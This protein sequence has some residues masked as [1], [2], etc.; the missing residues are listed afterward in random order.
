MFY[1]RKSQEVQRKTMSSTPPLPHPQ[2]T[3]TPC[4]VFS[5]G[6]F[7]SKIIDLNWSYEAR[8]QKEALTICEDR[9]FAS[10]S[11]VLSLSSVLGRFTRLYCDTGSLGRGVP[12]MGCNVY[13]SS[14][15]FPI[16]VFA[17]NILS[18]AGKKPQPYSIL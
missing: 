16:Y 12:R 7:H 1:L 9:A 2:H 8:A 5:S 18:R 17:V 13:P 15:T 3:R 14:P 6:L 4:W 11:C 10:F